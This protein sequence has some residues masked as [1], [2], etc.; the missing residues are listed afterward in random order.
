MFD[1]YFLPTPGITGT[2]QSCP[3][4]WYFWLYS[5]FSL[6]LVLLALFRGIPYGT[7]GITATVQSYP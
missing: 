6:F 1:L 5:E 3:Y 4:R 7:P 2:V